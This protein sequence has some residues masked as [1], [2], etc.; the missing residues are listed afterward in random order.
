MKTDEN[1]KWSALLKNI[2]FFKTFKDKELDQILELCEVKKYEANEYIVTEGLRDNTFFVILRGKASVV[3]GKTPQD[4][5]QIST[6]SEGNS[7]GEIAIV[8][9]E[10]RSASVLAVVDLYALCIKSEKIEKLNLE[11][12]EKL[13]RK[14]ATSLAKQLKERDIRDD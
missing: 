3:K 2:G 9:N 4:K 10:P 7:F 1:K 12:R 14:F 8:L 11:T 13:F 5:H 6:I